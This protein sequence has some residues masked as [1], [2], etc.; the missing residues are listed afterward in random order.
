VSKPPPIHVPA[1]IGSATAAELHRVPWSTLRHAYGIGDVDG[2]IECD[3]Q[4]ALHALASGETEEAMNALWSSICHQG[5]IYQ[6]T[7]Y[8]VPFLAAIAA[9]EDEITT[10]LKMIAML[11][12]DIAG[13]ARFETLDG[14]RAGSFGEGVANSTQSA[15]RQSYCILAGLARRNPAIA[16]F[17][18]AL[19]RFVASASAT[20]EEAD[21]LKD[22]AESLESVDD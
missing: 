17:V 4:G 16:P 6:A 19:T 11:L 1:S 3:V 21:D 18:E 20:R 2:S 14:T 15:F 12:A 8:A 13:A 22:L 10:R 5:T 7:P 9:G